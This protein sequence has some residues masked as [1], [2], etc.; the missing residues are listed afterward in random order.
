MTPAQK[1]VYE[2]LKTPILKS[3]T[4]EL[5]Q[6]TQIAHPI[7]DNMSIKGIKG[8]DKPLVLG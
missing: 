1:E 5:D 7:T 3:A 2:S 8:Y 6:T 4:I